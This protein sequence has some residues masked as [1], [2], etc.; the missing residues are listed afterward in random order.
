MSNKV[1]GD[2]SAA[3]S[4]DGSTNYLLIQ[5]GS[6]S[7]AYNKINR[8]VLLGVTGQPM[9]ISTSQNVTNKTLDNSNILTLRDDRFTLQDNGDTTKQAQFQLSGLTT[10]TTRTYTLP[11][12]SSTIATLAGTQVFTGANSFTG[13]SWSGGTIDNS[14]VTVDAISGHTAANT[15]TIYGIAVTSSKISGTV[16]SNNT[17]TST[18]IATNG[19]AASNLATNA[20]AIGYA[21]ITT[22][23][24]TTTTSS[25]V[26]VTGLSVTVT[27]PS[28][29]RN[30]KITA[31]CGGIKTSAVAGTFIN[32]TILEGTTTLGTTIISEPVT[33]YECAAMCVAYVAAPS[34][35]SH[36]Y[37][38]ATGESAAG[39]VTVNAGAANPSWGNYGPAWI[40]VEM[41]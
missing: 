1:I 30:L 41:I 34:Q 40:L 15:G 2:Y 6:S 9:D 11:D 39:T 24:T 25:N 17:I 16:I 23:F 19:I 27:V 18:Q 32:W 35:G 8:N 12:R 14:T 10:A 20:L 33:S 28:G 22:N 37:F 38:V 31:F 21:Q 26:A 7:T 3:V 5:P 29:S 36:T 4:I 13:S